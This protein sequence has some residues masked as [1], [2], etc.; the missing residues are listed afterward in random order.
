MRYILILT[1]KVFIYGLDPHIYD[2]FCSW[3]L[4]GFLK[5]HTRMVMQTT[6]RKGTYSWDHWLSHNSYF[7][8]FNTLG[9][10]LTLWLGFEA[11]F[12]WAIVWPCKAH[13]RE[14]ASCISSSSFIWSIVSSATV[15]FFFSAKWCI[16]FSAKN[17]MY[18]NLTWNLKPYLI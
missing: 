14:K 12:W 7:I 17:S 1:Y 15:P 16:F 4:I 11:L 8:V 3:G 18:L 5:Y 6:T 10:E 9:V 13:E 2:F